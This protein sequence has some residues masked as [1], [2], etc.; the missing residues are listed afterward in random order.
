MPHVLGSTGSF[1]IP[2]FL[3]FN[4]FF[5][6]K[7]NYGIY[8]MLNKKL[9]LNFTSLSMINISIL[10]D[11]KCTSSGIFPQCIQYSST[12]IAE[13]VYSDFIII[14]IN[15]T[16]PFSSSFQFRINSKL[17]SAVSISTYFEFNTFIL[18][19]SN[20]NFRKKWRKKTIPVSS[21]IELGT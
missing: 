16:L 4:L 9:K 8:W 5:V 13:Q 20:K 21:W 18:L 7:R 10:N 6:W 17:N 15:N 1:N 14:I 19:F 12:Y 11:S 3:F 2:F